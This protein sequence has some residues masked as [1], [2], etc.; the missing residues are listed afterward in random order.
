MAGAAAESAAGRA[1]DAGGRGGR[2]AAQG[3]SV[4]MTAQLQY[5]RS[6]NQQQ[7]VLPALGGASDKHELGRPRLPQHPASRTMHAVSVNYS[8]TSAK[9]LNH[10]AGVEDVAGDAGITGVSTDPLN[11][12]VP[13]LSFSS[14]SSVRDLTPSKRSDQRVALS[15]N[16]TWPVRTHQIRFGGDYRFDRS[17]S[18]SDANAA[19]AFVFTGLY[20]AGRIDDRAAVPVSTSRTSCSALSQQAT[21]QY[22][23]AK[24]R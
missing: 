8:S 4:N 6:E 2:G 1:A 24:S 5:R 23:P 21:V 10:Y 18:Q 12:G 19:G 15:Y 11:W 17:T 14:L 16:W 22:G 13:S 3:T 9:T 7:N 20:A